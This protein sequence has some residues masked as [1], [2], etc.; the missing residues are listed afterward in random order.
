MTTK[1]DY[2]PFEEAVERTRTFLGDQNITGTIRWVGVEDCAFRKKGLYVS[3][4][5]SKLAET[6]VRT[7]Y[8]AAVERRLGV[9]LAM[10]YEVDG[11]A[12]C[13]IYAPRT[14]M[15]SE[16]SLMGDGLKLSIVQPAFQAKI[17][18][19]SVVQKQG[20]RS[21]EAER[22]FMRELFGAA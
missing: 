3:P 17:V 14:A 18:D 11:L 8:A 1:N 12:L 22:H 2:P 19:S 7:T 10:L 16:Y 20:K 15:D 21:S 6:E 5:D 13:S 4:S 9:E